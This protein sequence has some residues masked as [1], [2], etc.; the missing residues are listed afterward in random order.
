ME[1]PPQLTK[2]DNRALVAAALVTVGL[3]LPFW[4]FEFGFGFSVTARF[5]DMQDAGL[6]LVASILTIVLVVTHKR[7]GALICHI[8]VG[9]IV[10]W[11]VIEFGMLGEARPG[12]GSL[13]IAIGLVGGIVTL[14]IGLN[15]QTHAS[16]EVSAVPSADDYSAPYDPPDI[17]RGPGPEL[18]KS[19]PTVDPDDPFRIVTWK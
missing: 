4:V 7:V 9:V 14:A 16:A 5:M 1:S 8:L 13:V 3:F 12:V 6:A 11:K 10:C 18:G 17:A 15:Q 19:R 2:W